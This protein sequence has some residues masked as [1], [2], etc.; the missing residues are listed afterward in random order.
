MKLL[1]RI[2]FRYWVALACFCWVAHCLAI[3]SSFTRK[4]G[5]PVAVWGATISTASGIAGTNGSSGGTTNVVSGG[6]FYAD[7]VTISVGSTSNSTTI[8]TGTN[9]FSSSDVGKLALVFGGGAV[10][11]G[12]NRQDLIATIASAS[13]TSVVLSI[14]PTITGNLLATIGTNNAPALQAAVNSVTGTNTV[15]QF[16]AGTYLLVPTQMVDTASTMPN[17]TAIWP[18][19]KLYGGGIT[20]AGSNTTLLGCGAWTKHGNYETRGS[21]FECVGPVTNDYPLIFTNLVIDGGV[22]VGNT[23]FHDFPASIVDGSGWDETHH[24]VVD[25]GAGEALHSKKIFTGCTVQN[26]RGE[27]LISVTTWAAGTNV[28]TNSV[29]SAN[30]ASALNF[31]FPFQL[32]NSTVKGCNFAM[33]FYAGYA[34]GPSSITGCTFTNNTG[35]VCLAFNGAEAGHYQRPITIQGNTFYQRSG[36]HTSIAACPVQNLTMT[37]N[38]FLSLFGQCGTAFSTTSSGYQGSDISSNVTFTANYCSNLL[39]VIDTSGA[40]GNKIDGLTV[41]SNTAYG[42]SSFCTGG[43]QQTNCVATYNSSPQGYAM[44]GTWSGQ[45]WKDNTNNNFGWFMS[46]ATGSSTTNTVSACYGG[47]WQVYASNAYTNQFYLLDT[48]NSYMIP[49]GDQLS[50]T[51]V[52]DAGVFA[53]VIGGSTGV[54]NSIESGAASTWQWS[55]SQWVLQ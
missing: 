9:T 20:F 42:A 12:T 22:Q 24:A 18:A 34:N 48:S 49:V 6:P 52:S 45:Y 11:S 21:M 29:F 7:A 23:A 2:P 15:I 28:I 35:T 32:I 55:G 43:G 5:L 41:S 30:N 51:N 38:N 17:A 39:Y 14:A 3:E 50:I 44:Y 13:G 31:S 19:V 40:W 10:T 54:T 53:K 33:E 47:H 16:G 37:G 26:W 27:A 1:K 25:F 4:T 8:T 36:G 46:A